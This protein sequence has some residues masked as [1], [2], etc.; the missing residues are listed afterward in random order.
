MPTA[1]F[2]CN[3]CRTPYKTE[4]AAAD[5]EDT[6]CD[7]DW[8]NVHRNSAQYEWDAGEYVPQRIIVPIFHPMF[9]TTTNVKYIREIQK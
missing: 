5:C 8:E 2:V 1:A 9:G 3:L 4:K 7:W 6:H